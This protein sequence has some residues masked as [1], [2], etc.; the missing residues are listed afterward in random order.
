MKR[1]DEAYKRINKTELHCHLVG[2]IRTATLINIALEYGLV[3]PTYVFCE[4]QKGTRTYWLGC[5][6]EF[7][8]TRHLLRLRPVDFDREGVTMFFGASD[9]SARGGRAAGLIGYLGGRIVGTDWDK[10]NLPGLADPGFDHVR[11]L[12]RTIASLELQR[13]P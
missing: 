6:F 8:R 4:I 7:L 1:F 10:N 11:G 9:S 12:L 3:L 2:A 13:M 5:P